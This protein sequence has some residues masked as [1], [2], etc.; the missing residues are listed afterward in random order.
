MAAAHEV[1]AA[2]SAA[3]LAQITL[4]GRAGMPPEAVTAA[5]LVDLAVSYTDTFAAGMC[6]LIE[7]LPQHHGPLDRSLR[8]TAVRLA[9]PDD[10]WA[11]LRAQTGGEDVLT[12]WQTRR[13]AL[14]VYR[15]HLARQRDPQPV[16][17]S[18]LHLH[19]V[20]TLGV[21]PDRERV[22]N[23]LARAVA[24]RQVAPQQENS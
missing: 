24:L 5:G 6:W 18:L 19:H 3:A 16:L 14:G 10:N 8:E 1:F 7:Q 20:R 22:T 12:T 13:A 23:R 11:A 21:G 15:D 17:R 2:D 4:A 9:D